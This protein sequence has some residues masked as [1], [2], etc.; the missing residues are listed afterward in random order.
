MEREIEYLSRLARIKLNEEEKERFEKE[1]KKIIDYVSKLKEVDTE[2]IEPTYHVL[3]VTNVFRE[4]KV[5][6]SLDIEEVLKNAPD[7]FKNFF[8]VPRII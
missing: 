7:R 8:K 3:P 5:E 1:L 2:N 6:K 4:D